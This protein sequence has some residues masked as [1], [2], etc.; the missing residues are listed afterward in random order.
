[1]TDERGLL[2]FS[3]KIAY[4]PWGGRANLMDVR[5]RF[6]ELIRLS[7]AGDIS[8]ELRVRLFGT[9]FWVITSLVLLGDI[10]TG[11][12]TTTSPVPQLVQ[13]IG[14]IFLIIVWLLWR[15][16]R[17]TEATYFIVWSFWCLSTLVVISEAGR[18]S[19][20]LVPQFLLVVLTRFLLNGRV[21]ILMGLVTAVTDFLIYYLELAMLLPASLHELAF[22]NDWPAIVISFLFLVFIFFLADVILRD[23]LQKARTT[24]GRYR[25]LFEKTNDAVFLID[26]QLNYIEVNQQ[27]AELL[28]YDPKE[29]AG[30]PVS[31]VIAP[32]EV[33]AMKA[34]FSRLE[35]E[36]MI[37]LFERTMI[38]KDG[39]RIITEVNVSLTRD[40]T[41]KPLYHQS[42][43]RDITERKRLEE[44]LRY[45]L[46]EMQALAM[47]DPLTGL[48]NRRAVT[49]HAE[50]EW[51]RARRENRPLCAVLIDLDNL[52]VVNDTQGHATG[53]LIIL[54]LAKAV[55]ANKRRYD[56]GG[57]WG[58]DEFLL[59]LPGA[60]LVEAREVAERLRNS[61]KDSE[62]VQRVGQDASVSLGIA[63]FSGRKGDETTLSQL[64]AQAD[65]AL[66]RAKEQGRDQVE[67]YRSEGQ[68]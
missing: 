14:L 35:R 44:Q 20:W 57:R 55:K 26:P 51:F 39:S 10:L 13:L 28:G 62:L 66:Y 46:E 50:A 1:M 27:A 43:I 58:G 6:A 64:L 38:R 25:S 40:E 54:E 22:G 65:Q 4:W 33:A 59:L 12:I 32:T 48:L 34:N 2:A 9:V 63:C 31:E 17:V 23:T 8:P 41:G 42:V 45:S 61:Y 7:R 24:E 3:V 29:L 36:D 56:W 5:T 68:G 49:E 60:N 11:G 19:H 47:Q 16:G 15:S 37:P 18:A 30:K 52:K 67:I 21:A 53:D